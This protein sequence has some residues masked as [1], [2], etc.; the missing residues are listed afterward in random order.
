MTMPPPLT[1]PCSQCGQREALFSLMSLGD[2][3]QIKPCGT[4]A[5]VIFR[6]LADEMEQAGLAVETAE[7]VAELTDPDGDVAAETVPAAATVPPAG[8]EPPPA[9]PARPRKGNKEG[10]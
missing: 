7:T 6:G 8:T 10:T 9:T 4:C 5:I 1:N 3:S 2:F